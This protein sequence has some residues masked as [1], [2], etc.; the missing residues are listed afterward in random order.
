MSNRR[1]AVTAHPAAVV[2][3]FVLAA[4]AATGTALAQPSFPM[5]TVAYETAPRERIWDGTI[6]AINQATVSAETSG[7][8]N[9][10]RAS[11][12]AS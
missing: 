1:P 12:L 4:L 2:R 3:A 6:E 8:D 11:S 10:S 7:S 9:C 5:V